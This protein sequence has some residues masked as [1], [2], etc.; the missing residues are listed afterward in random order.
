MKL[1]KYIIGFCI[2]LLLTSCNDVLDMAPDGKIDFV[3]VFEDPI[4]VE[5]FLNSCYNNMPGKG[6]RYFYWNRGPV[7][8]SDEAWDTDAEAEPTLSSGRLYN[9]SASAGDH[10]IELPVAVEA[11][12]GNYWD[13][14]WVA[15]RDCNVF[16]SEID[17]ANVHNE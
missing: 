16:I 7:V 8:W 15:I 4:K 1:K 2:P 5:A 6:T 11:G 9:G 14:Y 17:E 13:R 12:N 10:P 3:D